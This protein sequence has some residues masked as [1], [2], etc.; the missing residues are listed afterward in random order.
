M[1]VGFAETDI[2]PVSTE[3]GFQVHDPLM[4][5]VMV[6]AGPGAEPSCSIYAPGGFEAV[7]ATAAGLFS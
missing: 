3:E 6:I 5:R 4:A 7:L 1:R 2:T